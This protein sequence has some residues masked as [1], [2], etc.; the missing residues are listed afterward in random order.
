MRRKCFPLAHFW[1]WAHLSYRLTTLQELQ[2]SKK[3]P[4]KLPIRKPLWS[5]S[6]AMLS[7]CLCGKSQLGSLIVRHSTSNGIGLPVSVIKWTC[8][9]ICGSHILMDA[10]VSTSRFYQ[11]ISGSSSSGITAI[12]LHYKHQTICFCGD[13]L[14]VPTASS[15]F[16]SICMLKKLQERGFH[17]SSIWFNCIL[18]N[19]E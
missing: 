8:R 13:P 19:W 6:A 9:D 18:W 2:M 5:Q 14:T 7:H 17:S 10:W 12:I 3:I 16:F 4:D 11:L 15:N 1:W